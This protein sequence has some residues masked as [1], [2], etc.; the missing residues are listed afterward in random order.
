M[1]GERCERCGLE[2]WYANTR[3]LFGYDTHCLAH[4]GPPEPVKV[5]RHNELFNIRARLAL[6]EAALV[7][8]GNLHWNSK[9][10]GLDHWR[11]AFRESLA[12]F[13]S[14]SPGSSGGDSTGKEPGPSSPSDQRAKG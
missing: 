9:G 11:D 1:A 4:S 13:D 6:A 3:E 7:A 2:R 12:A 10:L 8:A 5:C 14:V